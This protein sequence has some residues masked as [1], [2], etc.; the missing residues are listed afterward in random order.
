MNNKQKQFITLRAD[1]ISFDKISEQLKVSKVTLIKWN[2]EFE[3]DIRDLQFEA[4]I[5]IKEVYTRNTKK[6]YETLLQQAQRIDEAILE[7]DLKK[8]NIKDLFSIKTTIEKSIQQI[9]ND[10]QF[11]KDMYKDFD[12]LEDLK[13]GL[14]LNEI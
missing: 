9:E 5:S 11:T 12:M 2:K 10:V 1:G 13:S 7:V 14:K 4:F 6:R 3:D 8:A